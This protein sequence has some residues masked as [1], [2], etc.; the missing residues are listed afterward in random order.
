MSKYL[1]VTIQL[2]F[3]D[4]RRFTT[5]PPDVVARPSWPKPTANE[6]VRRFGAIRSR[7]LSSQTD[8]LHGSPVQI[9]STERFYVNANRHIHT[10]IC[11]MSQ[12]G[13]NGTMKPCFL[14][15]IG[16]QKAVVRFELG[17]LV[18][19]D[20]K[21]WHNERHLDRCIA[22][23]AS[24]EFYS[25]RDD[26]VETERTVKP[27]NLTALSAAL[28]RRYFQ[29]SEL[30][31]GSGSPC[32]FDPRL[33]RPLDWSVV[34]VM[35]TPKP[36]W[37]LN[38]NNILPISLYLRE[39]EKIAVA[40]RRA[41][42]QGNSRFSPKYA[43]V[44]NFSRKGQPN[45][46]RFRIGYLRLRAELQAL[47]S[48][49]NEIRD[50]G[51][52]ENFAFGKNADP[53]KVN[54]LSSY[55]EASLN[56]V[57]DTLDDK[58]SEMKH[59]ALV[60]TLSQQDLIGPEFTKVLQERCAH[61]ISSGLAKRTS[62]ASQLNEGSKITNNYFGETQ[63]NQGVNDVSKYKFEGPVTS[64]GNIGDKGEVKN[65]G[66]NLA[67]GSASK[68]E[69]DELSSQL[70]TLISHIE[71]TNSE[72]PEAAVALANLANAQK[73]AEEGEQ[74]KVVAFLKA[75]GKWTLEKASAIG[76]PVAIEALKRSI[77]A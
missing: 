30:H 69:L 53:T 62:S 76:V 61:L 27:V 44:G 63:V 12:H 10:S 5:F 51:V 7:T 59:R 6:F 58:Q 54:A 14:R 40:L 11:G 70:A 72:E 39:K 67:V 42:T 18:S 45:A 37:W 26:R 15:L 52:L 47:W 34:A 71:A 46:R 60:A 49:T 33:L 24:A 38:G 23:L 25:L 1:F 48:V 36:Y 41:P 13:V 75:T 28:R 19:A 35:P 56:R 68:A 66:N 57:S 74:S 32:D 73:A 4:F 9:Q 43:I 16:D 31:D 20:A 2:P 50:G 22:V 77:G 29:A 8:S 21:Y 55:L 3:A 64:S 65:F 17:V